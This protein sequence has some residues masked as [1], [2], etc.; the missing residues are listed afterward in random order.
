MSSPDQTP[1][2]PAGPASVDLPPEQ[3]SLL[4]D[5]GTDCSDIIGILHEAA[6]MLQANHSLVVTFRA[7]VALSAVFD[8]DIYQSGR[9]HREGEGRG[10]APVEID[11][12]GV[13]VFSSVKT[14]FISLVS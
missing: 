7:Q 10:R 1:P 9:H 3:L 2:P 12:V 5:E 8:G 11:T 14:N 6:R 13:I 4:Q